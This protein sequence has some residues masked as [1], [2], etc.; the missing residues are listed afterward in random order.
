MSIANQNEAVVYKRRRKYII[1][2]S[3][4]LFE[5]PYPKKESIR[6]NRA[7]LYKELENSDLKQIHDA[8]R[9]YLFN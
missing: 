1:E 7:V 3:K 2:N 4:G 8:Y 9:H 5:L 6:N